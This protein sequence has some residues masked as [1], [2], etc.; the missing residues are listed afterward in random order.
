[1]LKQGEVLWWCKRKYAYEQTFIN[2][3]VAT[4]EWNEAV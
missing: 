3:F 2:Q 4:W 1:M